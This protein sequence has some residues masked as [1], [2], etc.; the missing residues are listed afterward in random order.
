MLI[1]APLSQRDPRWAKTKLGFSPYTI[2]SDGCTVT[3]FTMLVNFVYRTSYRVD[4][5]NE[6]LKSVDAFAKNTAGY[7]CLLI[8]SAA[9]KAYPRLKFTWR[10]YNYDNPKTWW[11][12][13]I[14]KM[15]VMVEVNAASIGAYRHWVLYL[16]DQKCVDPWVGQL[17]STAKYPAT[18][19]AF[20]Q[21]S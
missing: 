19:C 20:Y 4:E 15:P 21:L 9:C 5:V 10:A 17:V 11:S 7:K 14:L 13:N 12:I 8:W 2:G 1:V 6:K 18:G 16:G 3:A